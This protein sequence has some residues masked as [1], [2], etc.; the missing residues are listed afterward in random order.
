MILE[1]E[2]LYLCVMTD[3]DFGAL[4]TNEPQP[5]AFVFYDR[6]CPDEDRLIIRGH[7]G[8]C[9]GDDQIIHARDKVRKDDYRAIE[10]LTALTGDHPRSL[11]WVPAERVLQQ[12]E[13]R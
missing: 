6:L 8:I 5:G 2:R 1:A 9:T 7:C 13:D 4:H 11:G 12:P 10:Q 3:N